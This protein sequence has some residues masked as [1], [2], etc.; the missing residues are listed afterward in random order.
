M[1]ER[2]DHDAQAV[3]GFA[4]HVRRD[5]TRKQVAPALRAPACTH[6]PGHAP[7]HGAT[8]AVLAAGRLLFGTAAR[9]AGVAL[10]V[11]PRVE[12]LRFVLPAAGERVG[13]RA[14]LPGDGAGHAQ[15]RALLL[16]KGGGTAG[17][18]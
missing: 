17:G 3:D 2:W 7:D 13:R 5:A 16:V 12:R 18:R 15:P 10:F 8:W 11:R 1:E 14:R 6:T 9:R 4:L